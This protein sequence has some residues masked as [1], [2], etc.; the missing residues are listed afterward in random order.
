M[1]RDE[2]GYAKC[3]LS[4]LYRLLKVVDDIGLQLNFSSKNISLTS[5]SLALAVVRVNTSNFDTTTFAAQD[6]ENLLVCWHF[7]AK[8][9]FLCT[10]V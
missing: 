3:Q 2:S 1:S 8:H 6:S 10:I 9:I 5:A 4:S 7:C